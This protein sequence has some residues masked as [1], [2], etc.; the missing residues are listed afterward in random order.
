MAI[1]EGPFQNIRS[2]QTVGKEYYVA[3]ING[4]ISIYGENG[5]V[6]ERFT[7]YEFLKEIQTRDER[8]RT[9]FSNLDGTYCV[10]AIK[11]QNGDN[12][13]VVFDNSLNI[14]HQQNTGIDE[15][16]IIGPC[17]INNDFIFMLGNTVYRGSLYANFNMVE[18]NHEVNIYIPYYE[19]DSSFS[20]DYQLIDPINPKYVAPMPDGGFCYVRPIQVQGEDGV[21]GSG[22]YLY[23]GFVATYFSPNG[24]QS[25]SLYIKPSLFSYTSIGSRS[26]RSIKIDGNGNIRAMSSY[27][28]DILILASRN[29]GGEPLSIE[30]ILEQYELS[31]DYDGSY[32]IGSVGYGNSKYIGKLIVNRGFGPFSTDSY[33]FVVGDFKTGNIEIVST[34]T[35]RTLYFTAKRSFNQFSNPLKN[36]IFEYYLTR[37]V[38]TSA[39]LFVGNVEKS[40]LSNE[41]E[42]LRVSGI[43]SYEDDVST[44]APGI[45]V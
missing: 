6:R 43:G 11:Y 7:N 40:N 38:Y 34:D 19:F 44:I 29:Y 41:D 1:V 17:S 23:R 22:D 35:L 42:Y 36:N 16:K 15:F 9:S 12:G 8:L 30:Y 3:Q 4:R 13:F 32:Y 28:N 37:F 24:G 14:T 2:I 31:L 20:S 27:N 5:L 33:K 10:F 26:F 21:F 18:L 39:Y 25:K 45:V